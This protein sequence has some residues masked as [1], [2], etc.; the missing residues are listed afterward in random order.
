[1]IGGLISKKVNSFGDSNN[2][3]ELSTRERAD[4]LYAF[5]T[6]QDS[7]IVHRD[8][9][10]LRLD[11]ADHLRLSFVRPMGEMDGSLSYFPNRVRSKVSRWTTSGGTQLRS[12]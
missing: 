6:I 7:S 8:P 9:N 2:S 11:N 3:F 1:M 10:Y 5:I 12:R 4:F